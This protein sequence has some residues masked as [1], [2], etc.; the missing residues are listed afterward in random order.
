MKKLQL[1]TNERSRIISSDLIIIPIYLLSN[2]RPQ[3]LFFYIYQLSNHRIFGGINI[4]TQLLNNEILEAM[5][6]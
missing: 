1:E 6:L 2:V 5:S 3:Y 4:K